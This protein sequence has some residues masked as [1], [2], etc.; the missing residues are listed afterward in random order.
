MVDVRLDNELG[1]R[2]IVLGMSSS[3]GTTRT[4]AI[5]AAWPGAAARGLRLGGGPGPARQGSPAGP[6]DESCKKGPRRP[7]RL[8]LKFKFKM[9]LNK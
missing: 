6:P 5:R 2:Q 7:W 4:S 8:E 3:S 1:P 9:N